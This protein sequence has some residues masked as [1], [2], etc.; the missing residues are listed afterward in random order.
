MIKTVL[1]YV[2]VCNILM[3]WIIISCLIPYF[4][5]SNKLVLPYRE[6]VNNK[7]L[8]E[9]KEL[10]KLVEPHVWWSDGDWETTPDYW[11]STEFLGSI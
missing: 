3:S 6:F 1:T 9:M 5:H 10:A 7:I 11:K 2:P 8:P 4:Y